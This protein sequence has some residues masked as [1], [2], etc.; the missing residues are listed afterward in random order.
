MLDSAISSVAKGKSFHAGNF[1]WSY[2]RNT[3]PF[4]KVKPVYY[5]K[6]K[7]KLKDLTINPFIG[8]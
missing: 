1:K 4:T 3:I 8:F 6:T 7:Q 5:T 2:N